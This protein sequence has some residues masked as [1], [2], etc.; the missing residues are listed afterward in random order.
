MHSP[1]GQ[2]L[3]ESGPQGVTAYVWMGARLL[4]IMRGGVFYAS[5]NDQ[6]ERPEVLTNAA[7]QVVWRATND[8][9]WRIPAVDTVGGLRLG[10]PGQYEDV[11]SGLWYNWHR[12]FDPSIGRYIQS[13]PIGLAAGTNT[14]SYVN[15]SPLHAVDPSGLAP[16]ETYLNGW[17]CG[18]ASWEDALNTA[19]KQKMGPFDPNDPMDSDN[20]TAAEHYVFGRYL[21]SGGQGLAAQAAYLT[22]GMF[23]GF[24]YQ[25]A[26]QVNLY[27]N[28]SPPS[29]MQLYWEE[30][31]YTDATGLTSTFAGTPGGAAGGGAGA[32][33]CGRGG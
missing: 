19:R 29:Y 18:A 9:F 26:K 32:C 16:V 30:N 15:G 20:R 12:Y 28:A 8:A 3:Y 5:H 13:D 22:T 24:A 14:Y 7:A 10:F 6:L 2:L 23:W 11:E 31:A 1:G 25:G 21:G 4:G 27:P 33:G 17:V